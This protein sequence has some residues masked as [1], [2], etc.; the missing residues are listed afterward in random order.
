MYIWMPTDMYPVEVGLLLQSERPL[1]D[2]AILT[3][4]SSLLIP[5]STAE[6]QEWVYQQAIGAL[7]LQSASPTDRIY[8]LCSMPIEDFMAKLEAPLSYRPML[9]DDIVPFAATY[10]MVS[11]LESKEIPAR[12]WL[13][14]LMIGDCQFDVS[15]FL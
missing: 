6:Y 15:V 8:A 12:I 5:P 11:D 2:R 1:F 10:A 13:K 14:S 3:G 9:D 7:G 4:G